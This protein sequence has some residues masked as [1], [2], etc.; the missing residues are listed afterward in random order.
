MAL[1][2]KLPHCGRALFKF[3]GCAGGACDDDELAVIQHAVA[4]RPKELA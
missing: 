3:Q 1:F 2:Q 4:V